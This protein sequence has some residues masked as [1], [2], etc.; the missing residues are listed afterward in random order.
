MAW[1]LAL[2]MDTN[3]IGWVAFDLSASGEVA[4]LKDAGVRIFPDG[5]EPSSNG[6]VGVE[7]FCRH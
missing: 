6:R 7:S 2:D 4:A 5:R 3:S 1:R